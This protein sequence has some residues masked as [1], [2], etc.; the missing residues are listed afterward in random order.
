MKILL[1]ISGGVDSAYAARKL[2]DEGHDVCGAIL[3]MH[4]YSEID[5]ARCLADEIGIPLVVID[6]TESFDRIVKGNFCDEYVSGRTPNPCIIC[7]ERVKFA[8]LHS[9]AKANGFDKIATGH[10]AR[11][12]YRLNDGVCKPTLMKGIDE[13]K[14][15]SYMLYRLSESILADTVFPLG[16]MTKTDVRRLS[17]NAGMTVSERPDSQEICFLPDGNYPEFVEN[18]KGKCQSGN[19]IDPDGKILGQH[20][21]IIHYTVGQRKGLGISL[22]ER[23]FVVDINGSENTV[24][25]AS[26]PRE[27]EEV[28]LAD[29]VYSCAYPAEAIVGR[30]FLVKLRYSA[31]PVSAIVKEATEHGISLVLSKPSKCSPGQSAVAYSCDEVAFGG[32]IV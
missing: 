6:A 29:V 13:S 14:D 31:A 24:T 4:E 10:Y 2:L 5:S 9:Y 17:K 12:V 26:K 15:Q 1:G 11:I 21:G 19:F 3:R 25:L 28:S 20:K 23:S 8:L 27:I 30:S 22:G 16:E 18:V 7:N 32:V